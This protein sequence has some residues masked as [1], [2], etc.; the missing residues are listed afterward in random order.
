[1]SKCKRAARKL[2]L[3]SIALILSLAAGV[4]A[5]FAW[6][7]QSEKTS[8]EGLGFYTDD[9]RVVF[10]EIV[11]AKKTSGSNITDYIFKKHTDGKYYEVKEIIDGDGSYEF[12]LDLDGNKLPIL[13]RDLLPSDYFEFTVTLNTEH[14][15]SGYKYTVGISGLSGKQFKPYAQSPDLSV[16]GLYHLQVKGLNGEYGSEKMWFARYL[17]NGV[18]SPQINEIKIVNRSEWQE[19]EKTVTLTFKV[20]LD[21]SQFSE[22]LE[23]VKNNYG[24]YDYQKDISQSNMSIGQVYVKLET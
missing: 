13:F 21:F 2:L 23:F 16:L 10:G 4:G 22:M 8:F 20:T 11:H 19:G 17:N 12:V 15:L 24:V 18:I 9:T 1:M 3:S 6:F 7:L 14:N 5:A